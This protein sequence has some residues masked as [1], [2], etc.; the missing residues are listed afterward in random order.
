[1]AEA[2][3]NNAPINFGNVH[4]GDTVG[5][6]LSISNTAVAD[7]YSE[8]LNAS[9]GA[10]SDVRITTNGGS[11]SLLAAGATDNSSMVVG[12]DTAAAGVVSG[13]ATVN[14]ASDGTGTS[15]L[16]LY[17]LPSQ[18]VGVSGTILT[19]TV[20][21]L[22]NP[23]INNTQPVAFGNYREGDAVAAQAVSI[24][25]NVPD[26]GFSEGLNASANGT[27][28]GVLTNG[29][30]F[31]LLAA[32]QTNAT[33]ITVSIDTSV[34][35]NKGG[36]ATIDFE[37]D[38]TGTS[39]LGI[40]PLA[41]QDVAVSGEVYRLAAASVSPVIMSLNAR[42]GD[43]VQ[44]AVTIGNTAA[45]DGYSEELSASLLGS[46]GD[47]ITSG[48]IGGLIAAGATDSNLMVGLNTSSAGVKSG[49]VTIGMESD[50]SNTSGF[51]NNVDLGNQLVTVSGNVYTVAAAN[52]V[53]TTLDFGIVHVG[54]TVTTQALQVTNVAAVTA[55][56]D[57]LQGSF[58]GASGPFSASGDLGAGL[59][60]GES[61]T[62]SLTAGMDTT[63]AGI[64]TG[65][66]T[67]SLLS[68]NDDMVDLLLGEV[69]IA[70]M[71]QVNEYANPV[72]DFLSGEGYLTGADT[73]FLLDFG[74]IVE[75]ST[76]VLT[77]NFGVLN[78]VAA[79]ADLL[80]GLF[81]LSLA[82]GDFLLAGFDDFGFGLGGVY[83]PLTALGSAEL[84]S[85]LMLSFD[86]SG[87]GIGTYTGSILLNPF[88]FNASGYEGSLA[89]V[90][91]A[92]NATVVQ[93]QQVPEPGT[94]MLFMFG[95]II[96]M[97]IGVRRREY[98]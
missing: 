20:W 85:G 76:N 84:L 14:F 89:P 42:V 33:D 44:Q 22:A 87:Y 96:L 9:F 81:D 3:I 70:L 71:G 58:D 49:V 51:T 8:S 80:A 54:D 65:N 52:V 28:G 55:L 37:S 43:V 56:N 72:F 79:P 30:S 32:A 27:T 57:V 29:G 75:G 90:T 78:D 6:A 66:A 13:T 60:A 21:R 67:V 74:T 53:P 35:G 98:L 17:G 86:S 41:S 10:T 62:T 26:D 15:G 38:G 61:D 2:T 31:S 1:L 82:G 39:G 36:V 63:T 46:A 77:A 7:G 50:G 69:D 73:S 45:N 92:F 47:A 40:T 5:T 34:A 94:L 12:L 25:N 95:S 83:D 97:V 93:A 11:L 24:T 4:V 48:A 59:G 23:V 16:G 68:Y 19:A 91:L 64:Y 88:G 18:D